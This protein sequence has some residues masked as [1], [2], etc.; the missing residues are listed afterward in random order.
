[1]PAPV[2]E[3]RL[4]LAVAAGS[5]VLSPI[6]FAFELVL[7]PLLVLFGLAF[8]RLRPVAAARLITIGAGLAA[9]PL[10]YVLLA[11]VIALF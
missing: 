5:I 1:M 8:S 4:L 7:S 3:W 11:L 6:L 10:A 9:G 2:L